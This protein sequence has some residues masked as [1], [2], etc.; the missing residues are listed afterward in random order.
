MP[1][2]SAAQNQAQSEA[3]RLFRDVDAYRNILPANYR[4][5]GSGGMCRADGWDIS[6][7]QLDGEF[8]LD[9]LLA[10]DIVGSILG[11]STVRSVPAGGS[12]AGTPAAS[13]EQQAWLASYFYGDSTG[14][15]GSVDRL[16]TEGRNAVAGPG[17]ILG[18]TNSVKE[19]I[20]SAVQAKS[21]GALQ[22]AAAKIASGAA[23]SIKINQYMT[24]YNANK[25]GKG[26]P[27]PRLRITGLP[28]QV[29]TPALG[30]GARMATQYGSVA[31][32]ALG[33]SALEAQRLGKFA[34]GQHWSSAGAFFNGKVGTGLLTFAPSAA[35]DIYSSYEQDL[36]GDSRFNWHKFGVASA[37][38]QSGN[39]LG[40]GGGI[41]AGAGAVAFFGFAVASTPVILIS[42]G[43]GVGVQ[44]V[45]GWSG[46]ADET[47]SYIERTFKP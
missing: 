13:K 34:A 38:S 40:L 36:R 41:L 14:S 39:L 29:I 30:D 25:A 24:L 17:N 20:N 47:A 44:L 3:Q 8:D 26:R 2:S 35:L 16:L 46:K 43:V 11:A 18:N 45:W 27:R 31:A 6:N 21:A 4:H 9:D 15:V 42:L 28:L 37:K 7:H 19:A 5:H 32:R 23:S 12:T 1:S 33:T 10:K 22:A